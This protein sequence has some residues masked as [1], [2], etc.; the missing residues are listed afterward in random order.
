LHC[1]PQRENMISAVCL[2]QR[3]DILGTNEQARCAEY[4]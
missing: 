1:V 4:D 3:A 2:F